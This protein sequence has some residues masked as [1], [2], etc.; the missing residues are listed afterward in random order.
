LGT[1]ESTE[2][3]GLISQA[4]IE[5]APGYTY[6]AAGNLASMASSNTH[7]VSASYQ[8]DSLNRL[9]AAVDGNLTGSTTTSYTYDSS[10]NVATVTYPNGLEST[11]TYDTL[12]RVSELSSTPATYTYTRG[13][14]GNLTGVTESSG[15]TAAWTYDGIYRLTNETISLAPSG[16]NGSVGY[17]LDPVGNRQ[18]ETSSLSGVSS[19]TWSFNADDEISSESYDQNGNVT[20]AVGK[21]FSYDSENHLM[22]MTNGSTSATLVYDGD[23]SRVAKTVGGVTTYYLVDDLNP[24]GYPQVVDELTSSTVSRIYSYGLQRINENQPISGSW[25]PSF[26]GYDG[27]GNVRQLTNTAGTVT[28]SYEYDAFGNEFTVSGPTPNNY[29]YRGEQYDPDLG[30]YYLR[31]RYYNPAT[32]RFMSRDPENVDLTDPGSLHR[33]LYAK[34]DPVNLA[35]PTGRAAAAPTMPGQGIAGGS[36][37]EYGLI[38]LKVAVGTIAAVEAYACAVK[39]QYAMDALGAQGYTD[40]VPAGPCS[41]KGKDDHCEKQKDE[42]IDYC[43]SKYA[44]GTVGRGPCIARALDNYNRCLKGLPRIPLDPA[45]PGWS[46]D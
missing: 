13:A 5:V 12:N 29:L 44:K 2:V 31:A 38:V 32:G 45:S 16:K 1:G 41:A 17:G 43:S 25:T 42:D 46:W 4:S 27:G 24:T 15:R 11:F 40:I 33:Y 14:T 18:T 3:S 10:S 37:G 21:A 9:S 39:I 6:G 34:G 30:L 26:Y 19:G 8:Y 7:G 20:A 23:G 36:I 35:D 28:D 22:S